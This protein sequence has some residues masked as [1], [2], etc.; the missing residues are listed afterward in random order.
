[1]KM[2]IRCIDANLA[3]DNN[4]T[5]LTHIT[6][7]LVYEVE[8]RDWEESAKDAY[9]KIEDDSGDKSYYSKTRFAEVDEAVNHPNHYAAGRKYEPIEVINDWGLG[10]DLGNAVKYIS[11]AGRKGDEVEDLEKALFYIRHYI[12]MISEEEEE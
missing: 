12:A 11:R 10:F 2:K 7:G 3:S 8:K 9:I 6:E 5:K 4:A 1:M